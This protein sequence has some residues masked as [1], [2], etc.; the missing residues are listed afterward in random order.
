M[1]PAAYPVVKDLVLIGGG[2][3]HVGVIKDFA[4]R[5]VEGLRLTLISPDVDTPYSGMLPGLIAGHYTFQE[6][7]IDLQRLSRFAGATFIK[8]E[9]TG[10]DRDARKIEIAGRPPV[11]YD[12]VSINA[13]STPD[14]GAVPGAD[15]RVIPVK[16]VSEFLK[17][18]EALKDRVLANPDTRIGV[19]G[20]GAG[21][22]ELLLAA[23]FAISERLAQ[24]GVAARPAFHIV[25][26]GP[27]ILETH[28][29]SVRS[30]FQRI[31]AERNVDV[32]PEFRVDRVDETAVWSGDQSVP[33]DEIFWVTGAA[34]PPWL[35][36][37]GL[38]VNERGFLEITETLTVPDDNT[39]FGA[40]D[41]AGMIGHPRPKSGVFAVR[42][43]PPLAENLRRALLGDALKPYRPQK[44]FLSLISTGDQYAVASWKFLKAQGRW[45]WRWKDRI[46]REFMETFNDLPDMPAGGRRP[47]DRIAIPARDREALGDLDMRC[48][49]CAAKLPA[50]ALSGALD[51]LAVID[52]ADVRGGLTARDDAA[53]LSATDGAAIIQS[54]DSF[55]AMVSDPYTLG[56]IAANH[57]LGDLHAMGAAPQSAL[58]IVG[59]PP[60]LAEK[61]AALLRKILE[62]AVDVLNAANCELAGGHTSEASELTVGFAVTGTAP[63]QDLTR[64]AGLQ[65]GD[66]LIL[67]KPLGTG[68]IFAADMRAKARGQWVHG[69]IAV[70]LQSNQAAAS[71][72]KAHGARACTDVTGFGLAGHAVELAEA[73]SIRLTLEPARLP[74]I[75][76]AAELFRAGSRSSL[77][78]QNASLMQRLD[79]SATDTAVP[80][81]QLLFDPQTAG[82]LLAGV[83]QA[84]AAD[85]VAALHAAGY[86]DAACIGLVDTAPAS[87]GAPLRIAAIPGGH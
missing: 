19:V 43:G 77:H 40:G 54:V 57:C 31:L 1:S 35:A 4:M 48:G 67:T 66:A 28:N 44:A 23:Q 46:D 20:G 5:P 22:V 13:G 70:A 47:A 65:P 85:A 37:S 49:G 38:P 59:L 34:P 71:I 17:L 26:G 84:Q 87:M 42:Q 56:R 41:N 69:A 45:V 64:K 39:M 58:A 62:G 18:W 50:A 80:E 79:L 60:G 16:P 63:E 9:V 52:R 30:A 82:G 29:A 2:H 74:L 53:V 73:S 72:L 11:S 76:G 25:T 3:A 78:N 6:A 7:H 81:V 61:N 55:R 33:L 12:V 68:V 10:I 27:H 21:G 86:E 15:G 83:P 14:P 8:G 32:T 24:A 36:E 51:G 75:D